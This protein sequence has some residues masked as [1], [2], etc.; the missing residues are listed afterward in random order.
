MK[1][2]GKLIGSLL[3]ALSTVSCVREVILDAGDNPQVVVDC[4]LSDDPVQTL[5]LVYTKGATKESALEL[6]EAVATLADLS[7]DKEVGRFARA[8]DG[9]WQLDY[10]AIPGHSYRLDVS[11]PGH[12][13][14]W[15]EQTMPQSPGVEVGWHSWDPVIMD[16]NVGYTFS[17]TPSQC[18]VWFY[19]INYP[20]LDSP[21]E[22]TEYLYTNSP[23]VDTFNEEKD[24]VPLM[25]GNNLWGN[26]SSESVIRFTTYPDL[27]DA[28][29]HEH[30]LRFPASAG[31]PDPA[32]FY[33]S[34][35]FR[36]YMS[37]HKDFLHA[38]LRPAELHYFAASEDYDLF[39]KDCYHIL[40]VKASS[41][42]ADIF[43]RDNVHSNIHGAIGLFG[44]KVERMLELEGRDTWQKD[45]YFNMAGFWSDFTYEKDRYDSMKAH[46]DSLGI[47]LDPTVNLAYVLRETL[48][49]SRPFELLHY[50]CIKLG[51]DEYPELLPDWSPELLYGWSVTTDQYYIDIVQDQ[52]DLNARGLGNCGGIDFSKKKVLVF[53]VS[54]RSAIPTLIGYGYPNL[55][56]RSWPTGKYSPFIAEFG[57]YHL[58]DVPETNFKCIFRCALLVDKDDQIPDNSP[59]RVPVPGSGIWI[60]LEDVDV[61]A[62][63]RDIAKIE[64]IA[65]NYP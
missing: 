56:N 34:G 10:A 41:D 54:L 39:L 47:E 28:P 44:G 15:A 37:D 22:Q 16:N 32:P 61:N 24:N 42:M 4:I 33:V 3:L 6:T 31:E 59:F 51:N 35:N 65:W 13:P 43:M 7:E 36:G 20:T 8:A 1:G 19:G 14:I 63:M 55:F 30:Y 46:Y 26:E 17:L 11:V 60:E 25:K 50:E 18:P 57:T 64:N 48:R 29:L 2:S 52:E 58:P 40:G 23:K 53:A 21:G 62:V 45:G 38:E 12:E 5:Y 9:S 49:K 27:E